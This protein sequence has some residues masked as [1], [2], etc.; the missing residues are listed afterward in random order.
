M[1]NNFKT[2]LKKK[3]KIGWII[4]EGMEYANRVNQHPKCHILMQKSSLSSFRWNLSLIIKKKIYWS[5]NSVIKC[6]LL[7][8]FLLKG[9]FIATPMIIIIYFTLTHSS[10]PLL[11]LAYFHQHHEAR[12]SWIENFIHRSHTNFWLIFLM[13][14]IYCR[15]LNN[16]PC[17]FLLCLIES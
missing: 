13:R 4:H 5:S 11:L 16:F 8:I 1:W 7:L 15:H 9:D 3:G 12:K 6:R 17:C 10:L 2:F 14:I